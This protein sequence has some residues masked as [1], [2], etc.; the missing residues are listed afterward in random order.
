[1]TFY[2][3]NNITIDN[4]TF[5]KNY[6]GDDYL[7]FFA[8][9]NI[10]VNE[11]LFKDIKNDAIDSDFSSI[12]INNSNF[13]NIGNDAVDGSGS[14]IQINNCNFDTIFDKAISAGERSSFDVYDVEISNSEIGIVSKDKS[15]ININNSRF[16]NNKLDFASFIKK[17]F[18]GTSQ[19]SFNN[20]TPSSYL[21]ENGS[22]II[23][24]DTI[25][26]SKKVEKKLYGNMY[27]RASGK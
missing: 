22:D 11:S 16:N 4:S 1:M 20:S 27:G 24:L 6:E 18:F 23:G 10:V 26:Y 12:S 21:I 25:I 8:S 14:Q 5:E 17:D 3:S 9:K 2:N 15:Y 19:T 7:N 13:I